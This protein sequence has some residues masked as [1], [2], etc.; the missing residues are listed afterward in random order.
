[1]PEKPF[2]HRKPPGPGLYYVRV[3]NP[4]EETIVKIHMA[5]EP[6]GDIAIETVNEQDDGYEALITP[7]DVI[8]HYQEA[9]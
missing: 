9:G 7:D 5:I 4:T 3:K 1:M 6:T 8:T 2:D